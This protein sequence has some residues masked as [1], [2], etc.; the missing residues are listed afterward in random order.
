VGDT[1]ISS[2]NDVAVIS[3]IPFA[4]EQ[5]LAEIASN[6]AFI[7]YN[8]ARKLAAV[9]MEL[10]IN[11]SMNWHGTK[12]GDILPIGERKFLDLIYL[13]EYQN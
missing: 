1:S 11:E 13:I 9:E 4:D 12:L 3:D 10:S 7:P 2:L 6:S 8:I 5:A